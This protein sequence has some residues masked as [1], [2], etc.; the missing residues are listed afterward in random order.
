MD[1]KIGNLDIGYLLEKINFRDRVEKEM[2]KMNAL[3]IVNIGKTGVGKST[4]I[5]AVFCKDLA[6]T[7]IGRPVTQH[8]HAYSIS[9]SPVTIY[10]SKGLE[11]GKDNTSILD[12]I[13]N[14]VKTQNSSSNTKGYIHICWYCVLDG[15][16]RL[17]QNEVDIIKKLR[18]TIPVIIVI[19]QSGLGNR[20][21]EFISEIMKNFNGDSID[22]IPIMAEAK[23]EK[24]EVG[25]TKI[26]S[27]GLDKLVE[28]SYNLLPES[29]KKT[30]AAYQK[31]NIQMKI[32]NAR[33][34]CILY[35]GA[36]AAAAFQPL[37][38]A[39]AP[40]MVGIQIAMM[41]NITACFGLSPSEFDFKVILSGLGGSFAAAVVG[42]TLVSLLDFLGNW[43]E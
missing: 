3:N 2:K 24:S 34:A 43:V 8:C 21:G 5:N 9:D 35:S 15:G 41:V 31:A 13:Y 10:D 1:V 23:D 11:T 7:G 19:T 40:I 38:I 36:V 17:D 37:P 16:N 6:E 18:Q 26:N 33:T 39:D 29:V 4:I 42:R 32:N 28:K 30:F 22:I 27:H 20:T 25:Q 12:E 14:V